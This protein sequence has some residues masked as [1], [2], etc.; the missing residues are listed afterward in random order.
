MVS[1]SLLV[2]DIGDAV[3]RALP[4]LPAAIAVHVMQI[5][6]TAVAWRGL[7]HAPRPRIGLMLRA[8]WIRESLNGLLPLVGIGGGV[9]AGLTIARQTERLFTGVAAGATV[10]LLIESVM[11]LPFLL[12][13][14]AFLA[15]VAPGTLPISEAAAL[16]LP[17]VLTAALAV[18]LHFGIGRSWALQVIRRVGL[19]RPVD[20]L[21]ESLAVVNAGTGPML[22]A[23]AWHFLAWSLGAVEVWVILAVLGAP[24]SAAGAYAIES[25]G[26][27]AR[28]LGFVLPAGLGAQ[29]AGLAAVGVALGVPLEEAVAMSMLKR[30]REVLM[31]VPGLIIWQWIERRPAATSAN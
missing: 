10:D 31:S 5:A 3:L 24:T 21:R 17:L 18:M 7:F 30:L 12:A 22:Q 8:R 20:K 29:E 25:L 6:A 28:S 19:E 1:A 16:M 13:G 23:A 4:A 11:Q 9:L 27:A 26:M 15:S 2:L 14:L